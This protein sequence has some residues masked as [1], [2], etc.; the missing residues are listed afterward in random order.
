ME[1]EGC[2]YIGIHDLEEVLRRF[3]S[4]TNVG[5]VAEIIS[6]TPIGV[7]WRS[8][9]G[10]CWLMQTPSVKNL[11]KGWDR[12]SSVYWHWDAVFCDGRE[13]RA[14]ALAPSGLMSELKNFIDRTEL[15]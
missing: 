7:E 3:S 11:L 13:S 4:E 8:T 5:E 15:L 6:T 12:V 9:S 1:S 2:K 10:G 14:F